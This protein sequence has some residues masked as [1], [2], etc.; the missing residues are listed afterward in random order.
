MADAAFDADYQAHLAEDG[1]CD[2]GGA[3]ELKPFHRRRGAAAPTATATPTS[4]EEAGW[5]FGAADAASLGRGAAVAPPPS[6]SPPLALVLLGC[7]TI[8]L[9]SFGAGYYA[10]GRRGDAALGG[11]AGHRRANK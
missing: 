5:V 7:A 2:F 8:G 3:A 10:K 11:S 9:A 1:P 4:A 6:S